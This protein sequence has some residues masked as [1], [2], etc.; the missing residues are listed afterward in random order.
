MFAVKEGITIYEATKRYNIPKQTLQDYCR[1]NTDRKLKIGRPTVLTENEE[2]EIIEAINLMVEWGYGITR[3]EVTS[4]VE[5][6]CK[7]QKR[8]NPFV[9]GIPGNDWWYGFKKRHPE[10]TERIPQALQIYPAKAAT[11][12]TMD[13]WFNHT[14]KPV[15]D[16]LDLHHNPDQ[17]FNVD[18]SGFPLVGKPGKV[19]APH[20]TKSPQCLI[21]GSGRENITVQCCV[22]SSL[23]YIYRYKVDVRS[24]PRWTYW[25]RYAVSTNGWMTCSS[26]QEWFTSLFIPSLPDKN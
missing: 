5:S 25:R 3:N 9:D 20:G 21:A 7:S 2:S 23:Y 10:L 8:K 18:E 11:P 17:I 22:S 13:Q 19:L 12:H 6:F 16:K 15:L 4:I 26:F 14:L 24:H 1:R